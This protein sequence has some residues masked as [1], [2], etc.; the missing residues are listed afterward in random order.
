MLTGFSEAS[1]ESLLRMPQ[2]KRISSVD[3]M[4]GRM[5]I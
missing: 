2:I 5:K 4:A 1:Q 3:V